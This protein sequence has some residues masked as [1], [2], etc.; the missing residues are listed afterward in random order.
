MQRATKEGLCF[1]LCVRVV[2]LRFSWL[3]K[4]EVS[5]LRK[6]GELNLFSLIV[7]LYGTI[8]SSLPVLTPTYF[9]GCT[10]VQ[11]LLIVVNFVHD[12]RKTFNAKHMERSVASKFTGCFLKDDLCLFY[13]K[14][15][16]FLNILVVNDKI[17]Q[18]A[19]FLVL[20]F[21]WSQ[22]TFN[23]WDLPFQGPVISPTFFYVFVSKCAHSIYLHSWYGHDVHA[24]HSS[25][26]PQE[27]TEILTVQAEFTPKSHEIFFPQTP[28][29]TPTP[30]S[31]NRQL[32]TATIVQ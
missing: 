24:A 19:I 14:W 7:F 16:H 27:A 29:I 17:P 9:E 20:N 25:T 3:R 23:E 6:A 26:N 31:H 10:V 22:T 11:N 30:N 4:W 5:R 15:H 8:P 2:R 12:M 1:H 18:A 13:M 28:E 21:I 32:P